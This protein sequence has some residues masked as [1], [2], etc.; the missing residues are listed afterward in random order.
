MHYYSQLLEQSYASPDHATL[1]HRV[2]PYAPDQDKPPTSN[3]PYLTLP[4]VTAPLGHC[5][6]PLVY[7]LAPLATPE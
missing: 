7:N 4:P 1:W 3:S 2:N 6:E 5:D